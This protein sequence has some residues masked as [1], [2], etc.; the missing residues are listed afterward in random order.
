MKIAGAIYLTLGILGL[1]IAILVPVVIYR[2]GTSALPIWVNAASPGP[3]SVGHAFLGSQCESCHTPNQGVTAAACITCHAP[4][5]LALAKQSTAFHATIGQC[6]G[7]HIEHQDANSRP[8]KMDHSVLIEASLRSTPS[9]TGWEQSPAPGME[10]LLRSLAETVRARQVAEG[11]MLVCASCHG[12][13]DRH[14]ALFGQQCADC[15]ATETWKI[16]GFLHP[17]PKSQD[18]NQCHQAPQSHF[19]MHFSMMGRRIT[20]QRSA[21]VEQCYLCHQPGS[22]NDI[23]GVG[24]FKM[25]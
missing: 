8:T 1:A 12:F 21:R 2:S 14:R 19:M 22:F 24:W 10:A 18:C 9:G 16:A 3:L 20:G 15:H 11:E 7:C 5:A 13:R 6:Q 25:H 23:K 17:S 4:D